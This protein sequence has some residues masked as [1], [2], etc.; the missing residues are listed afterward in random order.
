VQ[1]DQPETVALVRRTQAEGT[2][3]HQAKHTDLADDDRR[4]LRL[5][6]EFDTQ[7]GELFFARSVLLV[8]GATEKLVLPLIFRALGHDL[9]RLGISVVEV[10]GKTKIR[11]FLRVCRALDIPVVALV[12]HD[13]RAM[14]SEWS[15]VRQQ[16]E[17]KSNTKHERWN[18]AIEEAAGDG[19]LFW[20]RSDFEAEAGL[21]RDESEKL[22]RALEHF[23]KIGE[24]DLPEV[25]VRAVRAT[26]ERAC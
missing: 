9:D 22:D 26:V 11:L 15:E 6:T 19:A 13:V 16:K 17:R 8:E 7:R 4:A 25:L 24:G 10:G 21:P 1:L 18:K 12:D 23:Q 14:D 5:L 3:I 20:M 2:R